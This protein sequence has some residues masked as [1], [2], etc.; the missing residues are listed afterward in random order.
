MQYFYTKTRNYRIVFGALR[1]GGKYALA[2][3]SATLAYVA[4]DESVGVVRERLI[5]K[6][7][8]GQWQ[9]QE[10]Q[11]G[12]PRRVG[13]REGGVWWGDG[14]IAGGILGLGVGTICTSTISLFLKY[15]NRRPPAPTSVH[16]E[17]RNRYYNGRNNF[18]FT[19]CPSKD[20]RDEDSE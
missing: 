1:T 8:E 10:S 18:S 19:D 11:D 9:A 6:H 3:S 5:G 16:E 13:W 17:Y 20:W 2:L 4:L 12:R 15:A 7:G 14:M